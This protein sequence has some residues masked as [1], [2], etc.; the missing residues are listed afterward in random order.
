MTFI[1]FVRVKRTILFFA[2]FLFVFL[3]Q[4]PAYPQA[5]N[6]FLKVE[7]KPVVKTPA[8]KDKGKVEKQK[9]EAKPAKEQSKKN[10]LTYHLSKL[11]RK[12]NR[13]LSGNIKRLKTENNPGFFVSIMLLC[14]VYGIAHALGPGHGKSIISSWIMVSRRR[15]RE[16]VAASG[17]TAV[18]HALSATIL[19]LGSWAIL[20]KTVSTQTE[21]L[22][23]YLHLGSGIMIMI[24]GIVEIS[25]HFIRKAKE[26]NKNT[27]DESSKEALP[28]EKDET[29]AAEEPEVVE[30][31]DGLWG[32]VMVAL[33]AG[34]V[35]C[36]VTSLILIFS[37]SMGMLWQGIV[38]V[39]SF[40]I[41]MSTAIMGVAYFVWT[42]REKAQNSKLNSLKYAVANVAP[43]IGG[44]A[45]IVFSILIMMT[46]KG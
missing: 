17:F 9:K 33:T 21:T 38:F 19:V 5:Q 25:K 35:P 40:A 32:S 45:L 13:S 26:K 31:R 3:L 28:D 14:L 11:Q 44:V 12:L 30:N 36:P 42:M 8:E 22:K 16:V 41:G 18:F 43:L 7:K 15:L 34:V 2:L 39:V 24:L 46:Y 20:K 23:S 10:W 1:E 27:A 29:R 37:L 4:Q 6:P